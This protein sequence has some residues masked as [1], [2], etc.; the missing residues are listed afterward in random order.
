[1]IQLLQ[2]KIFL[3]N[4][5]EQDIKEKMSE[6]TCRTNISPQLMFR[7]SYTGI[8][9]K[10]FV[11]NWTKKGFWISKFRLQLLEI[12]PDIIVRFNFSQKKNNTLLSIRY[13][14][15]LSSII[16]MFLILLLGLILFVQIDRIIVPYGMITLVFIYFF[17]IRYELK[18]TK[19]IINDKI[20]L[21]IIK[22]SDK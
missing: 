13:S 7:Q 17:I 20:L 3:Q 16:Q 12:R 19:R 9:E 4:N 22:K 18:R 11:G 15:G 21:D 10:F 6:L 14:L 8:T 1:M 5:Y 2:K